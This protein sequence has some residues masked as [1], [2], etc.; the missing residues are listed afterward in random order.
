MLQPRLIIKIVGLLLCA[1]AAFMLLTFCVAA[2]CGDA[3][4]W[5]LLISAG[6]TAACGSVCFLL[7]R[8]VRHA[9][10]KNDGFVIVSLFWLLMSFFGSMPY[11]LSGA[12]PSLTDAFFETVS[13]FT[14]TGSSILDHIEALPAGILFWRSLTQWLGGLGVVT[15]SLA[16]FPM[17]GIGGMQLFS[18]ESTGLT[19]DKISP[20]IRQTARNLWL[21]YVAATAL[22]TGLLCI[23]GMGLFDAI[24]HAFTTMSSGGY[25]TKTASV[26]FWDSAY[27]QYVFIVFMFISGINF[28]LCCGFVMGK[29]RRLFKDEEFRTY[30]FITLGFAVA[31]FIGLATTGTSHNYEQMFRKALFQVTSILTTTG[32][33]TADYMKW[34]PFMT[35]LIFAL[36]FIGGCAGSTSGG[37]KVV[38]VLVLVRNCFYELRRLLHPNAII[39]VR[40]NKRAVPQNILMSLLAFFMTYALIFCISVA[41]FMLIEPDMDTSIGAV[42]S[43]LGNIGPGLAKYGPSASFSQ[44]HPLGKWFMSFLML[45]G[46]LELF[47][48]LVLFS[49]AFWKK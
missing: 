24:N 29:S 14:T 20:K 17:F 44:L 19:T 46:R 37:V 6:I 45:L 5:A 22:Q 15:L 4:M 26:A 13:G 18:S 10:T 11:L 40:Y 48:V 33:I 1:I 8:K 36:F 42:A 34:A 27:I 9:I 49:P 32:F 2:G 7:N 47:T 39:P 3:S 25:S 12:I 31:I 28:A 21:F 30:T 41:L 38:R 23:G 16:I 35:M 43:S